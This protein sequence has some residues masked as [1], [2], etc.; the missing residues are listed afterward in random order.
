MELMRR[1][2]EWSYEPGRVLA[3]RVDK[4]YRCESTRWNSA[5]ANLQ[6]AGW[7]M[8]KIDQEKCI[9]QAIEFKPT[10]EDQELSF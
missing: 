2:A 3:A 9:F 5:I 10:N 1:G 7:E 8:L 6:R 4:K